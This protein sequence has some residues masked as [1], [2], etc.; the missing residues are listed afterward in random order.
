MPSGAPLGAAE[1]LLPAVVLQ[2]FNGIICSFG[3]YMLLF[4][5]FVLI[6]LS[7]YIQLSQ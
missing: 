1:V 2:F 4:L 7:F 3:G 5:A 6:A